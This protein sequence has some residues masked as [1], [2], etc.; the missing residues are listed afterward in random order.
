MVESPALMDAWTVSDFLGKW[1]SETPDQEFLQFEDSEA[2]TYGT[3][4]E[5]V[6]RVAGGL[7]ALGVS[8]GDRV[9]LMMGNSLEI[10]LTWFGVNHL[11]A[12]EVPINTANR[13]DFLIHT[14]NQCKA[15]VIVADAEYVPQLAAVAE[16][17]PHLRHVVVRGELSRGCGRFRVHDFEKVAGSDRWVD[18]PTVTYRD[19]AAIMYTSGTSGPSKGVIVPY[20]HMFTFADQLVRRLAIERH[21]T[22]MICLPLFHGNAQ[23]VQ[24]LAVLMTGSKAVI[25][26]RFSGSNWLTQIRTSGATV[27]SLLGVMAQ[28]IYDQPRRPDD[29][30][31]QCRRL[32]SIPMPAAIADEFK[33]RFGMRHVQGYGMT[34]ITVPVCTELDDDP[35]P[36]ASGR[37][38]DPWY[39]VAVVD[40]DTDEPV[41]VGQ[42]GEIVVR[43]NMPWAFMLGYEGMPQETVAAWRNFWFHT[44]DGGRFDEQGYLY[45]VDRIRDRIRRRGENLSSYEI[46][47]VILGFAGIEECAVVGVPAAEGDDDVLA[48][49]VGPE[50]TSWDPEALWRYC[51]HRMPYFAVPR[52][53]KLINEL[54]KTSNGKV[55]KRDL[56]LEGIEGSTDLGTVGASRRRTLGSATARSD[57]T[58]PAKEVRR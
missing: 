43:P 10:V 39:E 4:Y 33:G 16:S 25:F 58:Y 26:P 23:F 54:P 36:G 13:G 34:E 1:A 44:G 52:Y 30:D 42:I 47:S 28:F 21:D 15:E 56:R 22:F 53:F 20:G 38:T 7:S 24:L 50:R 11:G 32:I 17:L 51:Q 57:A 48:F 19:V 3:T 49:V 29:A 35:P 6:K 37:V 12:V 14:V 41:P 31:H 9:L 55:L 8:S 18:H 5:R 2:W 46:E 40:P 27:T 45:F